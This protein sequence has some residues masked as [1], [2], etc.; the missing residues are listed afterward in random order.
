MWGGRSTEKPDS[1]DYQS[2]AF[3][4]PSTAKGDY[5]DGVDAA[6][7]ES[8]TGE[9]KQEVQQRVEA[10]GEEL[11]K[12]MITVTPP[13]ITPLR[14]ENDTFDEAL[15]VDPFLNRMGGELPF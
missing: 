13:G 1:P 12:K 11:Q 3:Y 8:R 7:C 5:E 6:R 2:K 14:A 15:L 10:R 4:N 9:Q